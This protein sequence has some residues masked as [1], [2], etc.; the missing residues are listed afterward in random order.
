MAALIHQVKKRGKSAARKRRYSDLHKRSG[1]ILTGT[2]GNLFLLAEQV[3]S[4]AG[5]QG[6][7]RRKGQ[8]I[9]R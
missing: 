3:S 5:E 9:A 8:R 6:R 4:L 2:K 1:V 7:V